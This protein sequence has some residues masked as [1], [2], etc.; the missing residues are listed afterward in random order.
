MSLLKTGSRRIVVDG[1]PFRWLIRRKATYSQRTELSSCIN[2]AVE[3][4][5]R[6]HST[7]MILTDKPRPQGWGIFLKETVSPS[8]VTRWIR[9]AIE[10]GWQ[11]LQNGGTFTIEV[12]EENL[13]KLIND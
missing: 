3:H 13:Q 9:Q 4:A 12:S 1:K 8:E 6:S 11:P 7:L 2:I 10:E 5:E